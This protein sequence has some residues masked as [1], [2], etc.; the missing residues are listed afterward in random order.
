MNYHKPNCRWM[1]DRRCKCNCGAH[2][3]HKRDLDA[4]F[5]RQ[6]PVSKEQMG[7]QVLGTH[8]TGHNLFD[9]ENEH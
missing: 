1:H 6:A 2:R 8:F 5:R 7:E 9:G 4:A 3:R